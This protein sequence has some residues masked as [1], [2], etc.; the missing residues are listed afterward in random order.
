MSQKPFFVTIPHSGEK[1]P[2]PAEWLQNLSE[3]ILMRD[4]DRYVDR[5]YL[6]ILEKLKIPHITTEWHRY[7]VDLNRLPEDVDQSTVVGA[8]LAK[9][10]E[11]GF[12]WSVTTLNEKILP[13]PMKKSVHEDL[14]KIVYDPFHLKVEGCYHQLRKELNVH[15]IYQMDL[16]SMPSLGTKMHLDPGELRAD[17]VVSDCEQKSCHSKFR[18]LVIAAYAISGFK[19]GYNWPY[20]GG[21]LSQHYGRP[22]KGQQVIQVELNRKLYMDEVSKKTIDNFALVKEKLARAIEYVFHNLPV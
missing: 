3:E 11:R 14:R 6:P 18:D 12:H 2:A 10:H 20:K 1:I 13:A 17:V 4:V 19:V 21:R 5:L 22:E 16:H 8:S 15:T 7:A 9:G